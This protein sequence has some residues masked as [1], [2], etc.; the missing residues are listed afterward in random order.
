MKKV[1]VSLLFLVAFTM[2]SLT[3]CDELPFESAADGSVLELAAMSYVEVD[4]IQISIRIATDEYLAGYD[5]YLDL[6]WFEDG[7]LRLAFTANVMVRNFGAIE[8]GYDDGFYE[9]RALIVQKELFPDRP[10]VL[11]WPESGDVP[12]GISFIDED[13]E[14]RFFALHHDEAGSGR[15]SFVAF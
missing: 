1:R 10:L 3:G 11:T 13:D 2:L 12:R 5:E 14:P 7:D 6:S 4:G 8:L 15:F 9:S